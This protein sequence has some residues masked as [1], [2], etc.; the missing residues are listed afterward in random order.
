M[1]A[2]LDDAGVQRAV[3]AGHS[4]GAYVAARLAAE[5]PERVAS[6]VLVAF[7]VWA[8]GLTLA[9]YLGSIVDAAR[10]Y[11]R[12]RGSIRWST[13]DPLIAFG[14]TVAAS[15]ALRTQVVELAAE[16]FYMI[17]TNLRSCST[18]PSCANNSAAMES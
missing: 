14:F 7:T 17:T 9:I 3:V 11:R 16:I 2:V 15:F 18:I 13:I 4:M 5:H 10:R 6:L 12:L 1:L 8:L